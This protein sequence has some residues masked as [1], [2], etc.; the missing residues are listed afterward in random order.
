MQCIVTHVTGIIRIYLK[1]VL[2]CKYL[3]LNTCHPDTHYTYVSKDVRILGYFSKP[4]GVRE[5]KVWETLSGA[6]ELLF[7][8]RFTHSRKALYGQSIEIFNVKPSI[9]TTGI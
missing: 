9:L 2:R 7:V 5:Q 8:L 4:K 1:S 3:I 6:K